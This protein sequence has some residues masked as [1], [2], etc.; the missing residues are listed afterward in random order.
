MEKRVELSTEFLVAVHSA[1]H[2][3]CT[4]FLT[5]DESWFWFWLT[6]DH[7]QQWLP[8]SAERPTRPSKMA[9]SPRAMIVIFW[10][11]LV[12]PVIRVLRPKVTFTV[13]FFIDTMILGLPAARSACDP[14]RWLVLHMDNTSPPRSR[15]AAYKL[16]KNL[17][18][19][20]CRPAFSLD[21][22][23]YDFYLFGALKGNSLAEL[24]DP[25]MN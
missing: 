17:I 1:R 12:F 22:A 14:T 20:S 4:H 19:A 2:H 8:V 23:P 13:E 6:I 21:L 18:A 15:S 9:S 3:G 16:E 10:L 24:L 25:S 11:T 7:E 5:D